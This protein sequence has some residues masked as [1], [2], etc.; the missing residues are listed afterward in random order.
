MK[1]GFK[2]FD[3]D[4][5]VIY[6]PDLWS[7][8]LDEQHRDRIGRQAPAGL[9]HYNPVTVDGRWSQHPTS[10][11]G[12][13]QKAINW[14]TEDMIAKYGDIVA[15]GFTGDRVASAI[16]VEGVDVMVIY[17]PEYDMW[18]E[19]IDPELQAAMARAYNRWGA[20]M[21]EASGG[22]VHH[23]RAG[24]RSTTWRARSRRSSTRTTSSASAASGRGPTSSTTATSATATT[25]RSTSC[26]RTST[27]RSPRTST[28]GSNAPTAGSDRFD[29]FTE[30]H[31]VVHPHEAQ[32]ALLSMIVHGVYERF[33]RLRVAYMEAGCGWLPSWLHRIDEHLE[34]AGAAESPELTMSATDYFR[35]NCWISTECDDPFVADV[36]PLAGR[37][38]HRVR[39]RLPAPRLEVPARDRALPRA[40]VRAHLRRERSARSSGTTRSTSTGSPR[41]TCPRSDVSRGSAAV[42]GGR[43]R[44][45]DRA[46]TR[47]PPEYF[48]T[49]WLAPPD[50]IEA[51]PARAAAGAGAAAAKV[52]FFERRWA[53]A[54]FDP[55]SITTLDDLWRAPAYTVDD[56]RRSIEAHPPW[57]DYQGI[58]PDGRPARAD[59]RLHVGR[60]D[61]EVA[62]RPST[63][64]GTA[65]WA[66]CSRPARSTCRASGPATSCSTRGPTARTT[67]RSRST[68]RS[69][70]GSTASCHDRH[71]A[72]SRAASGRWSS[73]SSTAPPRSS[74]P[75][76]TC[77]ASP[78]SPAG[79]ATTPRP[80]SR[81]AALPNIGDRDALEADLRRRV[82]QVVRL[83][84]GAVGVGR[85]PRARRAPHLRGRVRRADRRSRDRASPSPTA[86][87]GRSASPSSTRPA[88][89]S[90]GTTSWT[91]RTC[92]RASSARAGAG[93]GAWAP[94]AGRGDNM[95]KLRGVNVWPEAVGDIAMSVD[96]V[97]PDYFVRAVRD[98]GP[99]RVGRVGRERA[100]RRPTTMR[101]APRSRPGSRSGSACASPPRS[102]R[103]AR[104]TP[105][106]RWTCRPKLKRFR[107]ER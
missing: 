15:E 90:S 39:D 66:R 95:V 11:Y 12:Q 61:R 97:A 49:A 21:R 2:V 53:D 96:G 33:P 91:S 37:R 89:R 48:E 74:R 3:A 17:G 45:A 9:D 51:T 94:F 67:A 85:V 19:G 52:P 10:I 34:L 106:P 101:C 86:S 92:T 27:A 44:R 71:R 69:T 77:S 81:S 87:S 25:T 42:G 13:F 1:D 7:R 40:P 50:V 43:L 59:A 68:R 41:G 4:A 84:R 79:W 75:A 47:P 57:G 30:W 70:A 46:P 78:T 63:R 36:D 35:R 88:A 98:D 82:L 38:P 102:S 24:A 83:P 14:T 62:A 76:T 54:G 64:S 80:T 55:R 28:W 103:R 26:C 104:S 29:T 58:L 22:R 16:A 99:R 8:F 105:G 72:T 107:D 18:L 5:H 60:H 100:R 20:E 6:P 56:I 65:R 93:C 31:T 32:C 73:R 23:V